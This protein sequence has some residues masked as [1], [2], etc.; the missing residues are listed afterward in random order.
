[1]LNSL[2]EIEESKEPRISDDAFKPKKTPV[3]QDQGR[4]LSKQI[5]VFGDGEECEQTV[6]DSNYYKTRPQNQVETQ[7][8]QSRFGPTQ[9]IKESVRVFKSSELYDNSSEPRIADSETE[10]LKFSIENAE[11]I[12]M[13]KKVQLSHNVVL[14]VSE[15]KVGSIDH[16][17]S[18]VAQN[19]LKEGQQI[20]FSNEL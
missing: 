13:R 11:L 19:M 16:S 9:P 17:H 15:Q 20:S 14:A 6:D 3:K 1:M 7:Q 5:I 8:R 2:I 18:I 12:N 4:R 10:L